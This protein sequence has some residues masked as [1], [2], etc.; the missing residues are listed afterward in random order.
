MRRFRFI[1]LFIICFLNPLSESL[2]ILLAD[3]GKNL[4]ATESPDSCSY[5]CFSLT[6]ESLIPFPYFYS[7]ARYEYVIFRS[8]HSSRSA[9]DV[10]ML[11]RHTVTK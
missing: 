8:S 6:N 4:E 7:F 9:L 5:L 11:S 2:D 10:L 3:L 1:F